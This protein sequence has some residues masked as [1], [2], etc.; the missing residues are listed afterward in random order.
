MPRRRSNEEAESRVRR[1]LNWDAVAAIIAALI[2]LLAILVSAY[3]V[4]SIRQQTQAQ[5]WPHLTIGTTGI[6]PDFMAKNGSSREDGGGLTAWN[7]GV[8]PAIVR[9]AEVLVNDEPESGWSQ[10]ATALGY[11]DGQPGPISELDGRVFSPGQRVYLI[12]VSGRKEWLRFKRKVSSKVTFR[13][14]YCSTLGDCWIVSMAHS[15]VS[16]R[17]RSV[18][19]CAKIP[20]KDEFHG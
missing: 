8:G 17:S 19:S 15:E 5:V 13:I 3:E 11:P 16:G 20:Q 7:T 9:R 10:V 1:R 14:C 12:A 18:G 4:R 2:G 6:L